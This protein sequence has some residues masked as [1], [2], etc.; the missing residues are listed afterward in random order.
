MNPYVYEPLDEDKSEI[1]LVTLLG[2]SVSDD[3]VV[4]LHKTQLTKD[5][6]PVYEAL[7]YAWDEIDDTTTISM[8]GENA[9]YLDIT[10]NLGTALTTCGV[11]IKTA[12]FGLMPSV[13]TK[14]IQRNEGIR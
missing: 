6:V 1:R 9:H 8:C 3:I 2:G 4:L 11:R 12:H 10:R 14:R 7:S 5:I 13:S